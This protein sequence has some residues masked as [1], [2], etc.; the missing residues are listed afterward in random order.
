MLYSIGVIS[1]TTPTA[2]IV[3]DC[4]VLAEPLIPESFDT[5][6]D[7]VITPTKLIEVSNAKKPTCGILW[8]KLAGGMLES[9]PPL[10]ELQSLIHEDRVTQPDL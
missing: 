9:I 1:S 5:V 3:H 10:L 7:F 6:C 2:A 4:Q 8:E